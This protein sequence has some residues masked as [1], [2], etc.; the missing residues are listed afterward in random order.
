MH[1]NS[2]ARRVRLATRIS[3]GKTML[4]KMLSPTI[5]YSDIM[6]FVV[7]MTSDKATS[8]GAIMRKIKRAYNQPRMTAIS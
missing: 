5:K 8:A 6:I 2:L 3:D 4:P 7:F 1:L